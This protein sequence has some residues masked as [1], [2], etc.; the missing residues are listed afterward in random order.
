MVSK[1]GYINR[2]VFQAK[3]RGANIANI[4]IDNLPGGSK[5]F[6]L[7]VNFCYGKKVEVSAANIAPLHCAANFL[8][9]SDD[10]EQENLISKTNT[11]LSFLLFSSWKDTF[12]IFKS[13][14]SLSPWAR[15]FGVL[16][17]CAE[18]VA[19]KLSMD[20]NEITVWE[21][22]MQYFDFFAERRNNSDRKKVVLFYFFLYIERENDFLTGFINHNHIGKR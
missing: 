15:E 11:F 2:L 7:V 3:H 4:P 17:R 12:W 21:N 18:A 10:F 1:S 22:E 16:S 13:C 9:M 19:W 5:I 8:E 14:E 20:A 6:E